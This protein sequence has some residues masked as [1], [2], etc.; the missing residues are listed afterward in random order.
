MERPAWM[1]GK[2][3]Q[4]VEKALDAHGGHDRWRKLK[5]MASTIRT[6]GKLWELKGAP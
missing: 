4:L 1:S 2:L 3:N 6:G 5:G